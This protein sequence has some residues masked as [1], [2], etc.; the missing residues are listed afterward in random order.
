MG[1]GRDMGGVDVIFHLAASKNSVSLD[2]PERDLA[3]NALGTLR[4]CARRRAT[5]SAASSTP[6]PAPSSGRRAAARADVPTRPVSY[7]GVSKLAGESY[8]RAVAGLTGSNTPS[9]ATTT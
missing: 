3:V 4:L 7:Y 2:D 1:R 9:C 8:C 6:P 5:T